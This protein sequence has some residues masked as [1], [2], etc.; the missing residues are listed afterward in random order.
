M[1]DGEQNYVQWDSSQPSVSYLRSQLLASHTNGRHLDGLRHQKA[2]EQRTLNL[3]KTAYHSRTT[4]LAISLQ[5]KPEES[6]VRFEATVLRCWA[7]SLRDMRVFTVSYLPFRNPPSYDSL[8]QLSLHF[9]NSICGYPPE[10]ISSTADMP[11]RHFPGTVPTVP[12]FKM[13]RGSASTPSP[14][15]MAAA[16]GGCGATRDRPEACKRSVHPQH[17]SARIGTRW[18][19]SPL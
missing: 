4:R 12:R 14:S 16:A 9:N 7:A 11:V 2:Q 18:N 13:T 15:I 5:V 10:V 17:K 3:D 8:P 6:M 1:A 19:L